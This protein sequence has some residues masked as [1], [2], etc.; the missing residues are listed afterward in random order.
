MPKVTMMSLFLLHSAHDYVV[1]VIA[2]LLVN[3]FSLVHC[4][5]TS[6]SSC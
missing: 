1:G 5:M 3:G 2:Q 6:L 4:G